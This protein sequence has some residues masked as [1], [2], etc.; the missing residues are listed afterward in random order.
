MKELLA[1]EWM[2]I[3]RYRTFWVLAGLFLLL[4]P[5]WNIEVA[6][7]FINLGGGKNGVNF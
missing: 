1:I 5:I 4:L 7:G 6:Y 2:K 3:R